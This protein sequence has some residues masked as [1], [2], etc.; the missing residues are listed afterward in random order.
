MQPEPSDEGKADKP[1]PLWPSVMAMGGLVVFAGFLNLFFTQATAGF[2]GFGLFWI[3]LGTFGLAVFLLPASMF[4]VVVLAVLRK[5][6]RLPKWIC[7][8]LFIGVGL[9]VVIC[10]LVLGLLDARP[11]S[12]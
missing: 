11:K 10:G 3:L 1:R 6:A 12:G 5:W 4:I 7:G 2:R 8:R 9:A